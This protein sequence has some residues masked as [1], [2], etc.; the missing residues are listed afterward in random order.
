MFVLVL[1]HVVGSIASG[2]AETFSEVVLKPEIRIFKPE[3][4]RT[5]S[6]LGDPMVFEDLQDPA[7]EQNVIIPCQACSSFPIFSY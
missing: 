6:I 2:K 4:L 5:L 3:T 7:Y 1:V